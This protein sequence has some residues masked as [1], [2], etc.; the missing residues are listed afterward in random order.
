MLLISVLFLIDLLFKK[1]K[2]D[3]FVLI[4]FVCLNNVYISDTSGK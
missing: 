4:L 2:S 3:T 1:K